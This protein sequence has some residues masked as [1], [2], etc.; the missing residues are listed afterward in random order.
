MVKTIVNSVEEARHC[1]HPSIG[2][3]LQCSVDRIAPM[4]I[5]MLWL[6]ANSL[7]N[8]KYCV[9]VFLSYNT[10]VAHVKEKI[11]LAAVRC[12]ETITL[13]IFS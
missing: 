10:R 13:E 5:E 8:N 11:R 7:H 6:Y 1:S 12:A 9:I 2:R 4:R 3:Y